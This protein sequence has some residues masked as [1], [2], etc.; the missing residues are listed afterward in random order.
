MLRRAASSRA[1]HAVFRLDRITF[2]APESNRDTDI[3]SKAPWYEITDELAQFE[4]WPP[5]MG[6]A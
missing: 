5:G 3:G 2:D 1:P 4:Q 6:Q